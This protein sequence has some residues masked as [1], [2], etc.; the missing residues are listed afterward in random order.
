M[1][2]FQRRLVSIAAFALMA[3]IAGCGGDK[4]TLPGDATPTKIEKIT[5]DGQAGIVGTELPLPLVVKVTDELGRPVANQAVS[6]TIVDG[7]GQV[8]AGSVQTGSDGRASATWTLGPNAGTQ[9]VQAQ[10][11]GDGLPD[12]LVQAF[13]GTAVAG[14]G[15]LIAALGG[16]DQTAPVNSAL[17]DSL[18]VRVSDASNNPVQ[19]ITIQ[20]TAVGGGTV[21][22]E[23]VVTGADGR[24]ATARVLGPTAGQQSAQASA[25]GLAGSPVTFAHTAVPSNPTTLAEVSGNNQTAPA[26]FELAESLVVRLTD[27]DGNGV[28]GRAIAWVVSTGGGTVNPGNATTDPNGFATT[29]W[30]LGSTAGSNALTAVFSGLTPVSFT[31]TGSSDVPTKVALQ[32]GDNQSGAAGQALANPLAVKVTDTNNNPVENVPVTWTANGG[33]SV[34]A[35]ASVT[36]AQ[37]IAQVTRTLGTA[38]GAYTTTATVDGLNGSPVTFNSTATA[39]AA[40]KIVVITQPSATAVNGVQFTQQP[41]VQV[42]D[43]AGN[44]VGP[45]GRLISAVLVN[46]EGNLNGARN[47]QTNAT[48]QATYTNLNITG[49]VGSYTLRFSSGTLA[50]A[51]SD[52]IVLSAGAPSAAESSVEASPGSIAVGETSNI[53][54]TIKDAG[55]NPVSGVT[56]SLL[57]S[58]S[59]NTLGQP[60]MTTDANG[61]TTGTF[62]S[63]GLGNH[64]ITATI[65][66]GQTV[67]DNAVVSVTAGAPAS[68][69]VQAGN[70]QTGAAGTSVS[71]PPAVVVRDAGNNPLAGVQVTFA[72]GSGGGSVTGAT[73][74][75]NASGIATVGSWTLGTAAGSN[76]NTLTATVSGSGIS[77][78]PVTFTASATAGSPSA[79]HSD[80]SAGPTTITAGGSGSTITVTVRDAFDNPISGRTINFSATGGGTNAFSPTAPTTNA[81]GVTTSTYTGT[82]AGDHV[83][84]ATVTGTGGVTISATATV[85]VQAGSATTLAFGQQPSDAASGA[86]ITPAVT[87]TASDAF[88]NPASATVHLN[89]N[90]P[91]GAMATLGGTADVATVSGVATFS[92]LSV[93]QTV[94]LL[95]AAYSLTASASGTSSPT[96]SSFDIN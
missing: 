53:T 84:S 93:D 39:G 87:V 74:T 70:N 49:P 14:S 30:T 23:T 25:D 12:D 33:G 54:V 44:N 26:G 76:N 40:A 51:F 46:T 11:V 57:A 77:G 55:G 58:G 63:T 59:G 88:G 90:V 48:G 37:G 17:A 45:A 27:A 92:D 69:A 35:P 43:A 2:R 73:P 94:N 9:H 82:Q 5:G 21:S 13:E 34:S 81:S 8:S 29:R 61:E 22:P 16:D 42:Q 24:A 56:V 79:S 18:V 10:V 31:A 52:P 47:R 41:V 3:G 32:S 62:T 80:V 20:W 72:I 65:N 91:A 89:L 50:D 6:Y 86:T 68:V 15:S 83:I 4:L 1:T 19:G 67:A 60:T 28:G 75:T 78:N 96:S 66:G 64:T 71:T 85:T 95:N 36:N 38:I 7:G